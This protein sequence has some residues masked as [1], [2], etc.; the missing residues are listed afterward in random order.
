MGAITAPV[1]G[2]GSEP[3]WT[4]LVSNSAWSKDIAFPP[5]GRT[6]SVAAAVGGQVVEDVGAGHHP[7]GAA[8]LGDQHGGGAALGEQLERLLHRHVPLGGREGGGHQ[9]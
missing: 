7:D 6:A 9:D 4:A 5:R 8:L 2:S 3:T 1:S